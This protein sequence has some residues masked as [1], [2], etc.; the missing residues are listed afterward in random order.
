MPAPTGLMNY[1]T[2]V[3]VSRTVNEMQDALGRAG[4]HRIMVEYADGEPSA[5]SFSL[6]TPHGER[7]YTLPCDRDAVLRVL[8]DTDP[9]L[10][11]ASKV[12][13]TPEQAARVSWRVL[14]DWLEAQL[15]LT[16][17]RMASLDQVMLPYLHVDGP[18]TLYQAWADNETRALTAGA[19]SVSE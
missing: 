4:A 15:A 3:P 8:Q 10:M 6:T 12:K 7:F 1:T 9:R 11:K 19:S 16:R 17:T 2:T 5:L 14:K 13:A 18:V